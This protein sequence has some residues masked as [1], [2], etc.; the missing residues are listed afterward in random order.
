MRVP[1]KLAPQRIAVVRDLLHARRAWKDCASIRRVLCGFALVLSLVGGGGAQAGSLVV[2]TLDEPVSLSGHWRFQTGDDPAWS[3]PAHDDSDWEQLWVPRGWGQQG[4][5]DHS[6]VAWFRLEL[7]LSQALADGRVDP[8][9]GVRIGEVT[10]SYELY[11]GGERIGGVGALPPEPRMEYDRHGVYALPMAAIDADGRLVLAIR[12]WKSPFSRT[13]EGGPTRGPFFIGRLDD[14]KNRALLGGIPYLVLVAVFAT[15]GLYHIRLYAEHRRLLEHLWFGVFALD[16]AVYSLLRTQWKYNL[17]DDF[18]LLKNLEY[19]AIYILPAIGLQ[20]ISSLFS[21]PIG[22]WLRTYQLSFV[23]LAALASLTP[24]LRFNLLTGTLFQL[25]ALPM[26]VYAGVVGFQECRRGHPQ[27]KLL[28]SMLF[29]ATCLFDIAVD[30]DWVQGPRLIPLGMTVLIFSMA[31]T[32]ANRLISAQRELALL[33]GTLESQV[34]EQTSKLRERSEQLERKN[35]E[36]EEAQGR[37]REASLTDPLT[38]LR[39][40]RFLSEYLSHDVSRVLRRYANAADDP[41][42]PERTDLVLLLLDL[43]HFKAVNDQHGHEAGDRV[44]LQT[45]QI[46]QAVCRTSDFVV[47]WGGEEFLVVSRFVSRLGAAILAERIRG[48]IAQH[49][50]DLGHGVQLQQT[51]SIGFAPFPFFEKHPEELDWRDVVGIAD[52]A[53]Y[54]AKESGRDGWVGACGVTDE[55]EEGLSRRVREDFFGCLSRGEIQCQTSWPDGD[56]EATH[57]EKD[58]SA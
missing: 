52:R 49:A 25:W 30:Q 54:A 45:A 23:A 36:L 3:D 2:A 10:S 33:N 21:R 9:L 43:D 50:F 7:D 6:G 46:L 53:L 20:L 39:N 38:G 8:R 51:C 26:I 47:R 5:R 28:P 48:A 35:C 16:I 57:A 29:L 24:G 15:V 31:A 56:A 55:P 44:L 41:V 34:V 14:L 42:L 27:A 4:Y 18:V 17:S 22:R 12:A 40:R 13:R 32:L 11:A 58:E 1:G 37:L 19:V